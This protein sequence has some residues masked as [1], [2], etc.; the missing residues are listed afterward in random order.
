MFF[1]ILLY[2]IPMHYLFKVFKTKNYK[3]ISIF[4]VNL[5]II[6]SIFW[7]IYAISLNFFKYKK[8]F[9]IYYKLY[10]IYSIGL[11]VGI[12]QLIVY[13]KYKTKKNILI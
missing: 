8:Y 2:A 1:N 9:K 7:L 11:I 10:I 13:F 12:S 3:I 6:N 5:N 4:S